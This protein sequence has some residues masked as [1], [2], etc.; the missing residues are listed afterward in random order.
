MANDFGS[1]DEA[2]FGAFFESS[3]KARDFGGG[4]VW[5]LTLTSGTPN[6]SHIYELDSESYSL[7]SHGAGP[8]LTA[9]GTSAT[10][11]FSVCLGGDNKYLLFLDVAAGTIVK[12]DSVTFAVIATY[13][14]PDVSDTFQVGAIGG[15]ADF[16]YLLLASATT[17]HGPRLHRLNPADMTSMYSVT[18]LGSSLSPRPSV[19]GD[20]NIVWGGN[21]QG[22]FVTYN[23]LTL[24]AIDNNSIGGT[25]I[26]GDG[27]NTLLRTIKNSF[28]APFTVTPDYTVYEF[29]RD[30]SAKQNVAMD[31][32]VVGHLRSICGGKK[33]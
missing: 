23:P 15:T 3:H 25:V 1:F 28:G 24:A 12:I 29:N 17:S 4:S 31:A 33:S 30:Y 22:H 32:A 10:T 18:L 20:E 2:G 6:T 13:S 9:S 26:F 5:V 11:F 14:V 7:I 27:N 8:N 21:S 19:G 16:V